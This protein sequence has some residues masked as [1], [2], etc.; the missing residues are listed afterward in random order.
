MADGATRLERGAIVGEAQPRVLMRS[1]PASSSAPSVVACLHIPTVLDEVDAVVVPLRGRPAR[2]GGW[3]CSQRSTTSRTPSRPVLGVHASF[4][5]A[6]EF[7]Q[8]P[9]VSRGGERGRRQTSSAA[10]SG[11]LR[12]PVPGACCVAA[13]PWRRIVNCRLSRLPAKSAPPVETG[14]SSARPIRTCRGAR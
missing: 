12:D 13:P 7:A 11:G 14:Q 5:S 2:A 6:P 3:T 4:E 8:W 10:P 9:D 1:T